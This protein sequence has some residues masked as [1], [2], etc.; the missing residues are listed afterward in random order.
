VVTDKN[1]FAP[2]IPG[3]FPPGWRW[4]PQPNRA[5]NVGMSDKTFLK[6]QTGRH[7]A[8]VGQEPLGFYEARIRRIA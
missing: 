2:L 3:L 8:R 4:E 5:H 1:Q 7:E 6:V